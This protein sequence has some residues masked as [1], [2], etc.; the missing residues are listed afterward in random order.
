MAPTRAIGVVGRTPPAVVTWSRVSSPEFCGRWDSWISGDEVGCGRC[1]VERFILG[2]RYV[3]E[4]AVE[5]SLVEPVDVLGDG[6]L[7]VVDAGPG[8]LVA[9]QLRLEQTVEGLGEGVGVIGRLLGFPILESE[10][11]CG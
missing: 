2:R 5:A 4:L 9:D 11:G 6:D 10:V 3:A 7:E 8:A 1:G